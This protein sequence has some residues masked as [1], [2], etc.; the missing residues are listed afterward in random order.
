MNRRN[1]LRNTSNAGLALTTASLGFFSETS[2]AENNI[3]LVDFDLNEITITELQK[4]M[5][6]G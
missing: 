1:F 4:K 3:G 5:A 6:A 2:T